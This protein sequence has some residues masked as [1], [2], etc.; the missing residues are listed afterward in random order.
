M[1][2][3]CTASC[4]TTCLSTVFGTIQISTNYSL[5]G[6]ELNLSISPS[7]AFGCL[8]CSLHWGVA[9]TG[10]TPS[11][12]PVAFLLRSCIIVSMG[13]PGTSLDT[14]RFPPLCRNWHLTMDQTSELWYLA[15]AKRVSFCLCP[16][17]PR[18]PPS[19]L[20]SRYRGPFPE[21]KRSQGMTLTTQPNLSAEVKNE[22][23][24]FPP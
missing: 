24:V 7:T 16:G 17:Q 5:R 13:N 2:T 6:A 19:I 12:L 11:P 9:A 18:D 20:S 10:C 15:E 8:F 3:V 4:V 1:D 21:L 22:Q 23:E 14:V